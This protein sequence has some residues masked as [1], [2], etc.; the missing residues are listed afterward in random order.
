MTTADIP[1]V[2][3]HAKA[4]AGFDAVVQ[5]V[6]PGQW[7]LPTPCSEWDV[8]ALVNHVLGEARWTAPLVAGS[9]IEEVGDRLD[10]DLL[11]GD[12]LAAWAAGREEAAAA[13]SAPEVIERTV[14]LSFGPTPAEEYLRQ[15]TADY[16]IHSWDLAVAIG[17]HDQLDPELVDAVAVWF[18][19]QAAAYRA[20]GAVAAQVQTGPHDDPQ[21]R[22]LG[23]FGRDWRTDRVG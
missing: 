21:R 19:P 16:L 10:G 15:L 1:V 8:H 3:L 7:T 6:S 4:L 13:T 18:A 23:M 9:T 20:A 5:Q 22:L 2:A 14:H 17:V 12:P 11:A